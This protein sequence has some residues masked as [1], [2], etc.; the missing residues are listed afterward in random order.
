MINLQHP[1]KKMFSMARIPTVD[2]ERKR[3]IACPLGLLLP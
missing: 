1:N 3:G 2:E